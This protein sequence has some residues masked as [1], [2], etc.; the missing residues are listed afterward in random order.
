MNVP[1]TIPPIN[2]VDVYRII[3][4]YGIDIKSTSKV[5]VKGLKHSTNILAS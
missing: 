4:E 3:D 1:A 5:S 2:D